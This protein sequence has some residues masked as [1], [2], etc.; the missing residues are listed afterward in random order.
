MYDDLHHEWVPLGLRDLYYT[1]FN[2]LN[3]LVDPFDDPPIDPLVYLE[4]IQRYCDRV[5]TRGVEINIYFPQYL[6]DGRRAHYGHSGVIHL[7]SEPSNLD[8]PPSQARSL[9]EKQAAEHPIEMPNA[10]ELATRL[11]AEG[12]EQLAKE[13]HRVADRL[14]LFT[15]GGLRLFDAY[16]ALAADCIVTSNSV[17]L[18]ERD[19]QN[20]IA[21]AR[22]VDWSEIYSFAEQFMIGNGLYIGMLPLDKVSVSVPIY[23][24][25]AATHYAMVD[26]EFQRYQ[27][28]WNALRKKSAHPKMDNFMRVAIFH[29]YQFMLHAKDK[30]NHEMFQGRKAELLYGRKN[31][32]NFMAS[33]HL[34][35]FYLMLWGCLDN[36]AWAFNYYHQLGFDDHNEESRK[37]CSFGSKEY[38]K[39]LRV[40]DPA[41]FKLIAEGEHAKWIVDL[42]IKRHPAAHR[43][44]IFLSTVVDPTDTRPIGDTFV[45]TDK[46]SKVLI[47]DALNHLKFDLERFHKLMGSICELYGV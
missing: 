21:D 28:L 15:K 10:K 30:V 13:L 11:Q 31:V 38:R 34:N 20:M 40:L 27:L 37:R 7:E 26:R 45:V 5:T 35:M 4:S 22:I 39:K 19:R 12:P 3:V 33:Y 47:Y 36:L 18:A 29:R 44:P 14:N 43:E 2:E 6:I 46:D 25:N 42:K 17:L 32:H 24:L 23:G 9:L 16:N 1:G 8:C 41:L